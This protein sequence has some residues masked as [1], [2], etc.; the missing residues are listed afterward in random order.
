MAMREILQCFIQDGPDGVQAVLTA[1]ASKGCDR[2]VRSG[3]GHTLDGAIG[4]AMGR[5][6]MRFATAIDER[7]AEIAVFRRRC[8]TLL[9]KDNE[10]CLVGSQ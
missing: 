3:R 10:I 5:P 8:L 1:P 2:H 7:D 9:A 4:A 6:N